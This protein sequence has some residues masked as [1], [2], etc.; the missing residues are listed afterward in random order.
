MLDR[1]VKDIITEGNRFDLDKF[2]PLLSERVNI[3]N[4]ECRKV[5]FFFLKIN[6]IINKYYFN[7]YNS[8]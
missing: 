8:F 1:L 7:Y 6:K 5:F 3:I 4:P 2:I